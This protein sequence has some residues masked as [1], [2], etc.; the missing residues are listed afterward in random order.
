MLNMCLFYFIF[1]IKTYPLSYSKF[2]SYCVKV[3]IFL[4]DYVNY[5]NL[6]FTIMIH[7]TML[8]LSKKKILK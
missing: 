7:Y 4:S 6:G 3:S 1:N 8:L 2:L 5:L